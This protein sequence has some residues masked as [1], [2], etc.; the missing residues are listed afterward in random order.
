MFKLLL[1]PRWRKVLRDLWLT[2]TRTLLV[3]LSIAVGVFAVGTIASAQIILSRDLRAMYL[4]TNPAQATILTIDSFDDDLVKAVDDMR[5]VAEAEARG[6]ISLRVKTG[7]DEWVTLWLIAVPDF[8]EIKI[9]QFWP[10][11]GAWPPPEH[12]LLIE[13]A[14]LSLV[15]AQVGDTILVK[16]PEGK[17]RQMRIAGLAHDLNAQMYVFGGVAYG[18]A[19]F[20]TL[21]WLG[22]ERSYNELRIVVSQ[23]GGL[24]DRAYIQQV[25]NKVR[26]KIENSGRS[27]FFTFISEPGQPPLD[28]L[29][30]AIT[31]IMGTLGVLSLLLSGFLVVNT[32]SAL[33]TQQTFQIGMMKAVGA[34]RSQITGMYLVMV[35]IF[36]LLALLIAVPLGALGAHT[37]TRYIASFLNFDITNFRLP[38]EVLGL[39]VAVG[40]LVPL[41]AALYPVMMGTRITAREAMSPYGLG[42]GRFGTS[43]LDRLLIGSQTGST[44]R[45]LLL[46]W[47]LPRP[48]LL[49][50]RNTFR[51]K[52]RLALT[53]TTLIL[54]GA[55]FIAVFSVRA[56][57]I[58]TLDNWLSYFQFDVDVQFDRDYR[59]ERIKRETLKVPGVVEVEPWGFYNTRRQRP[60][61][62]DSDNIMLMAPPAETR[63][64]KPTIV[65]GRWLRP[66]DQHAVV[67]NTLL[68]RDEPDLH[69]G[70]EL[71]LKIE[72][73]EEK[74]HVVGVATGGVMMPLIFVSY[75]DFARAAHKVGLADFAVITTQ[76]HDFAF[77]QKTARAM[78]QHYERIGLGIEIVEMVAQERAEAEAMFEVIVVLLLI[79][80]VLLAVIGGL[81]LMGT[82]SINV[83]ER[84]R[85]I[86]VMRA[87]GASNASVRQIFIV[88]GLIIGVL[89]WAVGAVLAYPISKLLSDAVG[90]QFLST[91]LDYTFSISG[92]LIWL[93]VVVF[94]SALASF[95]P[96]W[97][98][99]RLTVREVLAYE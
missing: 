87:I 1:S 82:M 99:S 45:P 88:E 37:F 48:L 14:A 28:F 18:F 42:R 53:L 90:Q 95:L 76:Q 92:V 58:G 71:T 72:G 73:R 6:R 17:E 19:T 36:G 23:D 21:E 85:E 83:L 11:Q 12:E 94:L 61:G 60:D 91:P 79:M 69:V 43:R 38:P 50:L 35:L 15:K 98:A 44:Q 29:I 46:R 3:V 33:L 52:G 4:A 5:E 80:A 64:V 24:P 7:P 86:G 2:K 81:G 59:I 63:L 55:I 20:D 57:L 13:R 93:V 49:S 75:P 96:A 26:D 89:S 62:S 22:Q 77:Q 66:N 47:R 78:E 34:R 25:A 56:S 65:E 67:V 31:I 84:T 40:L 16:T 74:F 10:E 32:I 27:V 68:L 9:D 30:Q 97:N 41:L 54:G 39:Q 8:D 51:R 70:S